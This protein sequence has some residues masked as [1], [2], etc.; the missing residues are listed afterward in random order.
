MSDD[1]LRLMVIV[2]HPDDESLGMGGILA[3]YSAEGVETYLITATRGERG[4][5]GDPAANPGLTALGQMREAELRCAAKTLGVG[6]LQI[7][8]YIDGDLDQ[9]HPAKVIH[10]LVAAIR[11]ARPHVIVTFDPSGA[12]G[13]PDHIAIC[14]HSVAAAVTAADSAYVHRDCPEA[15]R[16]P[17]MYYMMASQSMIAQYQSVFGDLVMNID[18]VDRRMLDVQD[19]MITTVIDTSEYWQQVWAAVCCHETQ[20]G[21]IAALSTLTDDG[22]RN[23]WGVQEFTRVYSTVNG[24]RQIE[25]DLFEGLR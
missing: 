17:K 14:Q 3:K 6:D 11:R 5:S 15:Y 19:W 13:H 25:R 21:S 22:H 12:Y 8:D 7:L 23:L 4:W 18:G 10:E 20:V 16:V 2:A 1:N 9:A 24:G